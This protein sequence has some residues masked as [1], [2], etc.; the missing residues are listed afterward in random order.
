VETEAESLTL[1]K[2]ERRRPASIA[3]SQGHEGDE[4]RCQ[5]VAFSN[6]KQGG[7]GRGVAH[8]EHQFVPRSTMATSAR[9]LASS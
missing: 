4:K 2:A 6:L 8:H 1:Q 5:R 7:K 3:T 9:A